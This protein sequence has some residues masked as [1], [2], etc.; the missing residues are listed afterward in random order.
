[1]RS[2]VD[3]YSQN[4]HHS[5]SE[6]NSTKGNIRQLSGL[7]GGIGKL[8]KTFNEWQ[9]LFGEQDNFLKNKESFLNELNET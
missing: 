1:M 5:L 3:I 9:R 6:K 8:K 4:T 2:L 7:Q